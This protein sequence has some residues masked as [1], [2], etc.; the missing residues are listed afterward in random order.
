MSAKSTLKAFRR[1]EFLDDFRMLL[2]DISEVPTEDDRRS[3]IRIP[4]CLVLHIQPLSATLEP[5]GEPFKATTRDISFGGIGFL[6]QTPFPSEYIKIR[7]TEH[8][9]SCAIARVCY[10]QTYFGQE[11]LCLVGVEFLQN[12]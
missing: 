9:A 8:S 11:K 5:V 12:K 4:Q 10:N 1:T 7:P 2:R 6:H 3:N